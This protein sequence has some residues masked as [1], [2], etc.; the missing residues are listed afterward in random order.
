VVQFR[1][2][3]ALAG[4]LAA[5]PLPTHVFKQNIAALSQVIVQVA[6]ADCCGSK[7]TGGGGGAVWRDCPRA[8]GAQSV[9]NRTFNCRICLIETLCSR[10]ANFILQDLPRA[11][12]FRT[13]DAPAAISSALTNRS[14]P[15]QFKARQACRNPLGFR[16]RGPGR[17][18]P[19]APSFING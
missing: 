13:T 4:V 15:M 6:F 14:R 9:Q 8:A 12:H 17:G 7:I 1:L 18:R 19:T 3:C 2:H 5:P 11:F 16:L 10:T